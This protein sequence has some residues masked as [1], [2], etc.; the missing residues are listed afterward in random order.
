[1]ATLPQRAGRYPRRLQDGMVQQIACAGASERGRLLA[2]LVG[3]LDPLV[4]PQA[5]DEI[6][7]SGDQSATPLLLNLAKSESRAPSYL[8]LKAI[9]ALGRLRAPSAVKCL[10]ELVTS[11]RWLGWEYPS[12]LRIVALQA[13]MSIAPE[14]GRKL[15]ATSGLS[16]EEMRVAP[17]GPGKPGD[18]VRARRYPRVA[19][20]GN[21]LAQ[22]VSSNERCTLMLETLSLGGGSASLARSLQLGHEAALEFRFKLRQVRTQVAVRCLL[23][24]RLCFEILDIGLDDRLR[25]RQY[26]AGQASN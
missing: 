21:V 26:L 10:S 2:S 15:T 23:D 13:I 22:A 9:E 17:I 5:L 20:A 24:F 1:M 18:W 19:L 3:G 16:E 7:I 8:Q 14:V 25:L 4:A 11:K 12:E 6:G